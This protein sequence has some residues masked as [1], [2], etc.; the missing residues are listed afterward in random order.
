MKK[1]AALLL[2]GVALSAQADLVAR[3]DKAELRLLNAACTEKAI[4]DQLKPEF[5][6]RFKAG[7]LLA[8]DGSINL[9]VCWI[10]TGEGAY[11]VQFQDG[12][13]G[14]IPVQVFTEEHGA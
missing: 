14:A 11:F 8:H 2:A 10:D 13:S 7:R 6:A 5:H 4:L 12:D 3:N 9:K 1:V